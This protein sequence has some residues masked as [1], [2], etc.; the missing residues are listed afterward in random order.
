MDVVGLH[1]LLQ[2]GLKFTRARIPLEQ[3]HCQHTNIRWCTETKEW[4]NLQFNHLLCKSELE[5]YDFLFHS[6]QKNLRNTYMDMKE[7]FIFISDFTCPSEKVGWRHFSNEQVNVEVWNW[8]GI[9]ASWGPPLS[10]WWT[11]W[12]TCNLCLIVDVFM[13]EIYR[14][15]HM[16]E[17]YKYWLIHNLFL[18][19]I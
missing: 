7:T 4:T 6:T 2:P 14:N 13:K 8:F 3:C 18:F 17:C 9:L 16:D 15:G 19:Q 1:L 11:R 12:S 10:T 5:K